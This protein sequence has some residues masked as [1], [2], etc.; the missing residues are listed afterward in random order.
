[1]WKTNQKQVSFFIIFLIKSTNMS[2]TDSITARQKQW[3][4]AWID[5]DGDTLKDILS[6][7]F[8]LSSARGRYMNRQE[9]LDGAL[10]LFN[11]TRFDW[12]DIKVRLYGD[13]AVVNA[14]SYQE[15]S[16]GAQD[17]SGTFMLTDVWVNQ[18]GT[19]RVVARQGTGPIN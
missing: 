18:D 17:W 8:L 19:W 15:A 5:K 10:A 3:M 7:D 9:W 2:T 11:C 16:V 12:K 1:V 4:Q 14:I 6:E 13:V